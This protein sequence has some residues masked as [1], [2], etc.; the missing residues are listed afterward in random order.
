M[1]RQSTQSRLSHDE[2]SLSVQS[3]DLRTGT[4][5]AIR[6]V[7]LNLSQNSCLTT[8][9]RSRQTAAIDA[10][11]RSVIFIH[12]SIT[13]RGG[14]AQSAPQRITAKAPTDATAAVAVSTSMP[15]KAHAAQKSSRSQYIWAA[16]VLVS[17]YA[18]WQIAHSPFFTDSTFVG[19]VQPA[20]ID[21]ASCSAAN[22]GFWT[23]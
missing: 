6:R 2:G 3:L 8:R 22:T 5:A 10:S 1:A 9:L 16:A 4:R 18:I 15:G 19:E 21:I 14:E 20:K 12:G 7:Y 17:I 11:I 23:G 13:E